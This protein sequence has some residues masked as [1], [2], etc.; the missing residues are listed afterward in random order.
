[1]SRHLNG[2]LHK[3]LRARPRVFHVFCCEHIMNL[4]L[5]YSLNK[6]KERNEFSSSLECVATLTSY[7]TKRTYAFTEYLKRKVASLAPT[8]WLFSSFGDHNWGAQNFDPGVFWKHREADVC[9]ASYNMI[10]IEHKTFLKIFQRVL[11]LKLYSVVF[12][13]SDICGEQKVCIIFV[14]LK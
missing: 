4:V 11:L 6:V 13:L 9:E 10:T 14:S 12:A 7:S 3:L 8:R 2:L 1:M 5:S